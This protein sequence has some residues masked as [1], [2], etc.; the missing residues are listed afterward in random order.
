MQGK[1]DNTCYFR[2]SDFCQIEDNQVHPSDS[3]FFF[4]LVQNPERF[5][6]YA[7]SSAHNVWKAIYEENCFGSPQPAFPDTRRDETPMGFGVPNNPL[8]NSAWKN[9]L[10]SSLQ[11]PKDSQ[12][13][14]QC[15]EK[16]VYYRL[17]SG[18]HASIS[19]HICD[20]YLDQATGEWKP[21]LDCFIS[22]IGEHPERLQNVYFDY[23]LL[24]RALDKSTGYL[25]SYDLSTGNAEEDKKTRKMVDGILDRVD[26]CEPT[27]D[28]TGMFSGPGSKVCIYLLWLSIR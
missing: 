27:F 5:T 6:G 22:R 8:A 23:V 20:E 12:E 10:L 25:R 14:E 19:I 11:G 9:Q 15:L 16:R 24:L 2:E 28:E 1:P 7:G 26:Q 18:L 4:D 21:N 13:E 3:A 17:I